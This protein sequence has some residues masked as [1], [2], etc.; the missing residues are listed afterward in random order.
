MGLF[1][2]CLISLLSPQEPVTAPPHATAPPAQAGAAIAASPN[3]PVAGHAGHPEG[4]QGPQDPPVVRLNAAEVASESTDPADLVALAI[5]EDPDIAA[6]AAWLLGRSK[7]PQSR[8]SLNTV[9]ASSPHAEARLQ[10][11][12]AL[13]IDADIPAT[14]QAI[15]ALNDADRRV[16]TIAAQLL[17]RLRRPASVE[18]LLDLVHKSA[19]RGGNEPTTDAQA[20]LLALADIGAKGHLLRMATAIHD[21]N[22]KGVGEALAYTFQ[23][24][25][26]SLSPADETTVLVAV[27]DHTELLVRRYAITRLTELDNKAALAALEGRLAQE[28]DALRPLLEIA[29]AQ[30]Q[31]ASKVQPQDEIGKAKANAQVLW[32][33]F[34]AWWSNLSP[35]N[36][37]MFAGGPVLLI[38]VMMLLRRSASRRRQLED[39]EAAAAW[40]QPSDEY[41]E[42]QYEDEFDDGE[43]EDGEFE[44]GEFDD[45]EFDDGAFE[46]GEF[47]DEGFE[48]DGQPQFD[49][50]GWEDEQGQQPI[51]EGA[52]PE[53][54]LFR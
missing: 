52:D 33:R 42:Q 48:D 50:S 30:L 46:D 4:A 2:L 31:N 16:R 10:A 11:I 43:F 54:E 24:L 15:L 47:D 14:E 41:L 27:L 18:P 51:P 22:A 39:A 36:Q 6:R 29:I 20:A 23:R 40:V 8:T 37:S 19:N 3:V 26:P 25:S 35:A 5:G 12:A 7:S 9:L 17:G 34:T 21:G 45:G 44:D 32:A 49:T 53:D 28:G 1:E 38:I 13:R